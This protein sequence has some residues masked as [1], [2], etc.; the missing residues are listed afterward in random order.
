MKQDFP[1]FLTVTPEN[2]N[3]FCLDRFCYQ[4]EEV[5]PYRDFIRH[6]GVKPAEIKHYQ[7]IPFLPIATF[8]SHSVF[9]NPELKPQYFASSGTTG[10]NQSK[11][12]FSDPTPYIRSFKAGFEGVYNSSSDWCILALLPNYLEQGESSLVFMVNELINQSTIPESGFFL[13]NHSDLQRTVLQLEQR[14][15]KTLLIGVSFALLDFLDEFQFNTLQHIHVMETG[16]MKGRRKEIIK[17]ELH[18]LLMQGFG[19]PSI[20]SEYGMTE[21]FSQAYSTGENRF[22]CPPW[23][24]ASIRELNDPLTRHWSGQKSGALNIIDLANQESCSFI[25]TEDIALLHADN[26]FEVL[27]RMDNSDVRGCNLLVSDL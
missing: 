16:G 4:A 5:T 26:T 6:L 20:H 10:T 3:A 25:A 14:G 12:Y 8:K 24:N 2:F 7:E 21:L 23:M 9:C 15:Q 1:D 27:G 11:H 18:H 13:R 19:V 17:A 22:T